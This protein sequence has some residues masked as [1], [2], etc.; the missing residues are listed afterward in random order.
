MERIKIPEMQNNRL[1]NDY[2]NPW[3]LSSARRGHHALSKFFL[4]NR[5]ST[6][7]IM[8]P[9]RIALFIKQYSM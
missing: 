6:D 7:A 3:F 1:L 2:I 5:Y 8:F 4:E 9:L